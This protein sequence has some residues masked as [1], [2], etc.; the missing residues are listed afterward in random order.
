[1]NALGRDAAD[2][3]PEQQPELLKREHRVW[4]AQCSMWHPIP[5]ASRRN[6][7]KDNHTPDCTNHFYEISPAHDSL[8]S[9]LCHRSYRA[10]T[11]QRVRLKILWA[12]LERAEL[13]TQ[14]HCER[15]EREEPCK[16]GF[17]D[18]IKKAARER[19]FA[20]DTDARESKELDL[21]LRLL[22][23]ESVITMRRRARIRH[24]SKTI[25]GEF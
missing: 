22:E 18:L 13:L 16:Y 17:C 20:R 1:M 5:Q 4:C 23:K 9:R 19:G 3:Q 10:G 7:R 11:A 25:S 8:H 15:P 6:D 21:R 24:L 14:L 12:V 2:P